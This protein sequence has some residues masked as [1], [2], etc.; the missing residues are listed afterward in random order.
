MA[1]PKMA[2]ATQQRVHQNG[3]MTRSKRV[4]SSQNLTASTDCLRDKPADPPLPPAA[5]AA[6]N[7]KG[8]IPRASVTDAADPTPGKAS[9]HRITLQPLTRAELVARGCRSSRRPRAP[10]S[11]HL[12]SAPR[13]HSAT[14]AYYQAEV[15][16]DPGLTPQPD[17]PDSYLPPHTAP[18]LPYST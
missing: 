11:T 12:I 8:N 17:V 16:A 9:L 2:N 4:R 15:S 5:M 13:P 6:K 14:Q 10:G 3:D 7:H 18:Y 1:Y